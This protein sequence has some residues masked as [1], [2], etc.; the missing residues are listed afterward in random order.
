MEKVFR[1]WL[2]WLASPTGVASARGADVDREA[3]S[4]GCWYPIRLDVSLCAFP[5]ATASFLPLREPGHSPE[6]LP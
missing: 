4:A 1:F 5:F 3:L 6:L 2:F